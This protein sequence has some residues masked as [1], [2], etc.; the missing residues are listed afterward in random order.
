MTRALQLGALLLV[1]AGTALCDQK[2]AGGKAAK[3]AP[4]P[5]GVLRPNAN[6]G[7]VPKAAP[8]MLP[9]PSNEI[10]QL[11]RMSPAQRDRI[12][13]KYPPDRQAQLRQRLQNF[14]N[15]PAAE[16]ERKLQILDNFSHLPPDKQTLVRTQIQA[17]NKLPNDRRVMVGQ[18]YV[19]LSRMPEAER[20]AWLD[21]N[22][23]KNR[24][25]PAEQQII[26]DLTQYRPLFPEE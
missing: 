5:R 22:P 13:E 17:Y 26:S 1:A 7:G 16:R 6:K 18:A 4:P 21:S 23:F 8:K 10:Q 15:Q 11:L 2:D 25:T 9:N 14:D 19:R 3:P 20:R 12:L 24:F